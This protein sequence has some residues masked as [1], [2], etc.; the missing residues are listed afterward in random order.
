MA[1]N[2]INELIILLKA[3][4]LNMSA[5]VFTDDRCDRISGNKK[6]R[7]RLK[8]V[9]LVGV[10]CFIIVGAVLCIILFSKESNAERSENNNSVPESEEDSTSSYQP[11]Y[12]GGYSGGYTGSGY[13]VSKDNVTPSVVDGMVIKHREILKRL[14][15]SFVGRTEPHLDTDSYNAISKMRLMNDPPDGSCGFY[16]YFL[17]LYPYLGDSS[18]DVYRR[19]F[20]FGDNMYGNLWDRM[21]S[22]KGG[23]NEPKPLDTMKKLQSELDSNGKLPVKDFA[24]SRW[25]LI[26]NAMR[27]FVAARV[28][29]DPLR[30][31]TTLGYADYFSKPPTS[32]PASPTKYEKRTDDAILNILSLGVS[33]YM[34]WMAVETSVLFSF[35]LGIIVHTVVDQVSVGDGARATYIDHACPMFRGLPINYSMVSTSSSYEEYVN[36]LDTYQQ[37]WKYTIPDKNIRENKSVNNPDLPHIYIYYSHAHFMAFV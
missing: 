35:E 25:T 26:R 21:R 4:A 33:S 12:S 27:Y 6:C 1:V 24:N 20:D 22:L 34:A 13:T 18:H 2:K 28:L 14:E 10:I 15:N 30:Q 19:F 32:S 9:I 36:Q 37:Y 16:A 3:L 23:V 5:H 17:A 7:S 11:S 8:Y 31:D 29:G